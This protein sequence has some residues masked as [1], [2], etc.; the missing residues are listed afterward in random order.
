MTARRPPT[1]K[2]LSG[3]S[4]PDR[5]APEGPALPALDGVP[6]APDWLKKN[7]HAFR[8]WQRLAPLMVANKL[9]HTGNLGL[10]VQCCAIYG[11][12]AEIWASGDTPAASLLA[13]H[14]AHSVSLG[15]LGMTPLPAAKPGNKFTNNKRR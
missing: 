6:P 14:R 2:L 5:A 8:E 10:F 12:L 15:L 9:L 11:R 3:T 7:S 1:L 13:T 4:R